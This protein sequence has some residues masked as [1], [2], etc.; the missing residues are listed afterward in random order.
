MKAWT[1]EARNPIEGICVIRFA[2]SRGK[3]IAAGLGELRD[4]GEADEFF[5][6]IAR[7]SPDLDGREDNPP[8]MRELVESHGWRTGCCDCERPIDVDGAD[9]HYFGE[10]DGPEFEPVVWYGDLAYCQSCT[11]RSRRETASSVKG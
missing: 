4:F 5:D 2:E 7:R 11:P 1:V 3:A 8:T 9:R 10:D 6:L